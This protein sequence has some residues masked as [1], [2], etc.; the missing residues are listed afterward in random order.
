[1]KRSVGSS[2]DARKPPITCAPLTRATWDDFELLFGANGACGGCW[3]LLHRI[4]RA[5]YEKGKGAP[6]RRALRAL[7]DA[8]RE[9]GLVAYQ[10]GEPVGWCSIEPRERFP[11]L[12]RSR[13]ARAPDDKPAWCVTCL[14]VRKDQRGQGVSVALL[15]AAVEH[16]REHGARIVDGFPVEPR[17]AAMPAAFAW[18]G[19]ASAFLHAGFREVARATPTRPYMRRSIER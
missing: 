11:G 16:A 17:G 8:G 1:M 18:T 2:L 9:P 7:V 5:Q 19:T 14:F 6:N 12:A 10:N 15:R 4:P 3:C 13:V